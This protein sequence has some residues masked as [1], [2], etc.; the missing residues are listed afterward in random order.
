[1]P[2]RKT[3][4]EREKYDHSGRPLSHRKTND[5]QP[6]VSEEPDSSRDAASGRGRPRPARPAGER[7]RSGR[8]QAAATARR[9]D[10]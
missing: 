3:F 10:D 8:N 1:M 2:N 7:T 9:A 4:D 5:L 6:D